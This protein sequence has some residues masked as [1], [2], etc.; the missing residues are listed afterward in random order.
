MGLNCGCLTSAILCV[1]LKRAVS[2]AR[3]QCWWVLFRSSDEH[4]KEEAEEPDEKI[5]TTDN[6]RHCKRRKQ[7]NGP[8]KINQSDK[9]NRK[10]EM[11]FEI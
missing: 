7:E 1:E 4:K 9:R 11:A 10:T 8:Q 2:P 5:N 3:T 6:R